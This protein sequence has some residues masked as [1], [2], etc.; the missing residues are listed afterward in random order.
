[1]L[2]R[3]RVLVI[4]LIFVGL[5][6]GYL[7]YASETNEASFFAKFPFKLGLDLRGGTHLIY[8]AD[9]SDIESQS[10]DESLD[11]LRDVIERRINIFGVSEPIVQTSKMT[12]EHGKDIGR[13]IV[14]LPEVTDVDEATTLI[15]ATPVLDF[16]IENPDIDTDSILFDEGTGEFTYDGEIMTV[17]DLYIKTDL[18]GRHL[19]RAVLDFNYVTGQPLISLQFDSDG[20]Q[21]FEKMTRENI[22]KTVAIYLDGNPI[23]TP[24]VQEEITGGSAQITGNF[25]NEE[26]KTLV[27]RLNAGALPIPI[28]LIQTQSIGASL[29]EEAI[30]RGIKAGIIGFIIVSLFFILWY[31]LPGLLAVVSLLFYLSVM[32]ALFKLIPVTITAAGIAGFI[33]SVGLAVDANV[34]IF[35]RFKE[36]L[37]KT[38]NIESAIKEA[39]VRAW[40]SI[41]DANLTSIITAVILFWFGTSLIK[42]F[43]LTFGLGVLVSMFSAIVFTK[44]MMLSLGFTRRNLLLGSGIYPVKSPHSEVAEEF[45]RIKK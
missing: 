6:L 7:N 13:L 38:G 15:G 28:S 34:L 11:A 42:G 18:T 19:K 8:E 10:I 5:S 17:H 3:N 33:L 37:A 24:V 30:D 2:F 31:R 21:L 12:D 22:G 43:A 9:V 39:F 35:E 32:F 4:F 14:E 1:M 20:S 40:I 45:N 16:R 23:S 36:E 27:G 26:A 41:R 25:T 29:G 44:Q